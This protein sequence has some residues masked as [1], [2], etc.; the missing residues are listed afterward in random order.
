MRLQAPGQS[1]AVRALRYSRG[2][3]PVRRPTP[4][5]RGVIFVNDR[6]SDICKNGGHTKIGVL[7]LANR[8]ISEED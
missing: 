4:T 3:A 8:S 6:K 1:V 5:K 2:S 7:A